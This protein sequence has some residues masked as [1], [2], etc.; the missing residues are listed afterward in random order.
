MTISYADVMDSG[1]GWAGQIH[2]NKTLLEVTHPVFLDSPSRVLTSFLGQQEFQAFYRRKDTF[3]LGICNGCQLMALLGAVPFPKYEIDFDTDPGKDEKWFQSQPRF[4]HNE[5]ERFES[6]FVTL[7]VTEGNPSIFLR[8]P[9]LST[10]SSLWN[11]LSPP[12]DGG[13]CRDGGLVPGLLV[14]PRGGQG[15]LPRQGHRE[16]GAR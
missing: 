7:Q 1:K 13:C 16:G 5:S 15:A 4:I 3:S 2:F 6:R 11:A 12:M 9:S 8:G 14:V 10:L